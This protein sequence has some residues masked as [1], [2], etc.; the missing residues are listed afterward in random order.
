MAKLL[1]PAGAFF[2]FSVGEMFWPVQPKAV[3]NLGGGMGSL[4]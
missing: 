4:T 2:Q 3:E 1:V